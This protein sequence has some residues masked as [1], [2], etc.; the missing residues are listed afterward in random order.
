MFERIRL[1]L[2]QMIIISLVFS[3]SSCA[4]IFGG[5]KNTV[6]VEAGTPE[7]AQVYL[8]GELL[9]EAPFKIRIS[10]YKLQVG[11]I[12]EIKKEG[13][14][15]MTYEVLRNP[16]IGY[17]VAD[18]LGGVIPLIIDVADGNI[19]RPNTRKIEYKLVKVKKASK[20]TSVQLQKVQEKR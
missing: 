17:V 8:D 3:L 15:T 6:R 9:G 2:V 12:I 1:F 19:Y 11:S 7:K 16:H 18:I 14:K 13:F 5:T 4:T 10:K 20:N